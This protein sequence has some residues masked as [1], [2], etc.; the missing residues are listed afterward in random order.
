MTHTA[1]SKRI[2]YNSRCHPV[3]TSDTIIIAVCGPNDFEDN[4]HPKRDGCF[5]SDFYLFH[6]LF[7]DTA[8]HQFWLTCVDPKELAE[9]YRE[10]AHGDSASGDRRVVLD[11]GMLDQVQDVHVCCPDD[12]LDEF[13]TC[14]AN[15]SNQVKGT[16]RTTL[17][18]IFGHGIKIENSVSIGGQGSFQSSHILTKPRFREALVQHHPSPALTTLTTSCYGGGWVQ[19]SYLNA[20]ALEEVNHKEQIQLCQE[21]ASLK[22]CCGSRYAES[23]VNDLIKQ[24]IFQDLKISSKSEEGELE[25]LNFEDPFGDVHNTLHSGA[26]AESPKYVA[27]VDIIHKTLLKEVDM[28]NDNSI[29]FSAKDDVWEKERRTRMGFP[30]SYFE[31]RWH[32]LRRLEKVNTT[33]S[34]QSDF[35]KFSDTANLARP[36]AEHR[37]KRLA[38]EYMHSNPG[39]DEAA[40]NHRTHGGCNRLLQGRQ[41]ED[42]DLENLAAA[43]RYRM[44]SVIDTA[45]EYKDWLGLSFE[46]CRD[47]DQWKWRAETSRDKEKKDRHSEL[48]HL[49]KSRHLFDEAAGP[50]GMPFVKGMDYI[51]IIFTE[52]GWERAQIEAALNKM[53]VKG[54]SPT[55]PPFP[56]EPFQNAQKALKTLKFS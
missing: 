47:C 22:H 26:I 34:N 12:L 4:A 15:A 11:H 18:L 46:D 23:V 56:R 40:K 32:S 44:E 28:R 54:D 10:Y 53:E 33:G 36:E 3:V 49:V 20:T 51:A 13:L 35:I 27:L 24:E 25:S 29:S 14:V 8:A 19:S 37:L 2:S 41:L 55:H 31:E 48:Y 21:T 43:L 9:K 45:T 6:H 38:W 30:L 52:S 16:D 5:F 39:P 7:R 17:I 42:Y 50:D 1:P